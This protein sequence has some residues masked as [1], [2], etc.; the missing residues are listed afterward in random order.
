MV[1]KYKTKGIAKRWGKYYVK[2]FSCIDFFVR[3]HPTEFGFAIFVTV[4]SKTKK[5]GT[6][7]VPIGD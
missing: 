6:T 1:R 3:Q 2:K 4:A 5:L 7:V